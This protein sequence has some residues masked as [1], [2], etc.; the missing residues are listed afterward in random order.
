MAIHDEF[1]T[2]AVYFLSI[3]APSVLLFNIT[4]AAIGPNRLFRHQREVFTQ[5]I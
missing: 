2:Y 5:L 1:F 3:A 4:S